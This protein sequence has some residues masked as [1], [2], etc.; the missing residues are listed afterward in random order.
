MPDITLRIDGLDDA[1]RAVG[2]SEEELRAAAGTAAGKE[3][4]LQVAPYPPQSHAPQPFRSDKSRRFFFAA[5]RSGQ[6]T[7]PYQR[8]MALQQAWQVQPTPEGADVVNASAHAAWTVTKATQA[9]YHAGN[10][11]TEEA[12]AAKAA[13][14]AGDA[15]E[16]AIIALIAA[17]GGA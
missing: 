6:I 5:L 7:V 17:H 8:T 3:T 9:H 1:L 12:L 11:Q 4:A 15:A 16:E 14:P 13:A 10:W 2:I